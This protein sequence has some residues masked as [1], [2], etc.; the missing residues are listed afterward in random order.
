[1]Q[2][3]RQNLTKKKKNRLIP[4][5][6]LCVLFAIIGIITEKHLNKTKSN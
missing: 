3:P 5:L 1:M 4:I 2:V 6:I